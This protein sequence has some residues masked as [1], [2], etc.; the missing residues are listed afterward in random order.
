[1]QH[2]GSLE[3]TCTCS[4]FPN[5]PC[6]A[7][8]R[9][10]KVR[11]VY[12]WSIS[13]QDL[14]NSCKPRWST[15]IPQIYLFFSSGKRIDCMQ[16]LCSGMM[17]SHPRLLSSNGKLTSVNS[18]HKFVTTTFFTMSLDVKSLGCML[19]YFT[20]ITISG[21]RLRPS[22]DAINIPWLR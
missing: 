6:A 18:V 1:M 20:H 13:S 11:C 7:Y 2:A 22:S 15:F 9:S 16:H 17:S 3:S 14:E 19:K 10:S 12:V 4:C 8:F 5:F 21:N